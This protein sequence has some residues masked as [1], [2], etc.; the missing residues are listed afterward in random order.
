MQTA[1]NAMLI[2]GG[3]LKVVKPD[4]KIMRMGLVCG[5]GLAVLGVALA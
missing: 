2:I 1:A 3:V 5:G 4:M